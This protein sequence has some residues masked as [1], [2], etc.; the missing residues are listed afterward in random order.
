VI[1]YDL[2]VKDALNESQLFAY[3]LLKT[4]EISDCDD[5]I[6]IFYAKENQVVRNLHN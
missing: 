4:W 5:S 1:F 3:H 2:S 6:I